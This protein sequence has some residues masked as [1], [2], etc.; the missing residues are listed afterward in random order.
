MALTA[1]AFEELFTV[2][3]RM[4]Y[5]Y[6]FSIVRQEAAAEEILSDVFCKLWQKRGKLPED[7]VWAGY[8]YRS[9]YHACMDYRKHHMIKRK[10]ETYVKTQGL[11]NPS[12]NEAANR[13]DSNDFQKH[14]HQAMD[15]LPQQCQTIFYLSRIEELSYKDIAARL[16][17]SVKTVEVQMGRALKRLRI[18][19]SDFYPY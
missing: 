1:T 2:Q 19:L 4:L 12:R 11:Q 10:Y 9:V 14:L 3:Y 16:G 17:L 6:A 18:S 13:T 5:R 15:Q 8:L 7:T